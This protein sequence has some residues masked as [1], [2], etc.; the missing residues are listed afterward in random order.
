MKKSK[1][2]KKRWKRVNKLYWIA[3]AVTGVVLTIL[4]L[5]PTFLREQ[6]F[7]GYTA[8]ELLIIRDLMRLPQTIAG[9]VMVWFTLWNSRQLYIREQVFVSDGKLQHTVNLI[10]FLGQ[11]VAFAVIFLLMPVVRSISNFW[12]VMVIPVVLTAVYWWVCAFILR[13]HRRK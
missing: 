2:F 11:I 10:M 12:L 9:N 7:G 8:V 4:V 13:P 3:T 1:N 5:L 6:L